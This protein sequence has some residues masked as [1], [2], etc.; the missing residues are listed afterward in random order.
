M[1]AKPMYV[2]IA[3]TGERYVIGIPEPKTTAPAAAA[4][5]AETAVAAR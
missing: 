5:T 1:A 3:S 4:T 2:V